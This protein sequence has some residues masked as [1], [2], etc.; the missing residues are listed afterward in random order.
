MKIRINNT[1]EISLENLHKELRECA[2]MLNGA[3]NRIHTTTNAQELE[4]YLVFAHLYLSNM[5]TLKQKIF[6]TENIIIDNNDNK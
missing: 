4:H 5:F 2:N 6:Y 1:D 3:V